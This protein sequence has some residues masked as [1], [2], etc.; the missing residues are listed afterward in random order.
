MKLCTFVDESITS[1]CQKSGDPG[2]LPS[3]AFE[4]EEK[5]PWNLLNFL[6]DF[7]PKY[8]RWKFLEQTLVT[9]YGTTSLTHL[10][11]YS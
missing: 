11:L 8:L 9:S 6:E 4:M 5:S 1:Q 3:K 10:K 2:P 7:F